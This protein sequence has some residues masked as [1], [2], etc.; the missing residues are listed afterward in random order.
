MRL[1]V[2][3]G[4]IYATAAILGSLSLWVM[5][6]AGLTMSVALPTAC[7]LTFTA[8]AVGIIFKIGLPKPRLG[9]GT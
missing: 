7:I 2:M 3:K 4:E 9:G 8:R 6:E 5:T 1:W